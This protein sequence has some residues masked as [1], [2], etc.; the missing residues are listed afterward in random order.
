MT[1]ILSD[2]EYDATAQTL[3]RLAGLVFDA[4]RRAA[5]SAGDGE[6]SAPR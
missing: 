3:I 2:E 6:T 4:S 5:L 1:R